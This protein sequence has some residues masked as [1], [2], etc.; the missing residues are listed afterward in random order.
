MAAVLLEEKSVTAEERFQTAQKVEAGICQAADSGP[1]ASLR[2]VPPCLLRSAANRWFKTCRIISFPSPHPR[3]CWI[4]FRADL[5]KLQDRV[6]VFG[7]RRRPRWIAPQHWGS[8][9]FNATQERPGT[10]NGWV[11]V[12]LHSWDNAAHLERAS[13]GVLSNASAGRN[14]SIRLLRHL[15]FALTTFTATREIPLWR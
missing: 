11:S 3:T 4:Y 13:G 9:C 7:S 15:S 14:V 10:M 2:K 1:S 12:N 5:L 8:N 6:V